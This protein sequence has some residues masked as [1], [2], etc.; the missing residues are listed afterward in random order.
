MASSSATPNNHSGSFSTRAARTTH[1]EPEPVVS[2]S[3]ENPQ[4]PVQDFNFNSDHHRTPHLLLAAPVALDRFQSQFAS[5]FTRAVNVDRGASADVTTDCT[6]RNQSPLRAYLSPGYS[7]VHS[8]SMASDGM[9]EHSQDSNRA[10]LMT[11]TRDIEGNTP[12]CTA[13]P[14]PS[15]RA[16]DSSEAL[17]PGFDSSTSETTTTSWLSHPSST[18]QPGQINYHSTGDQSINSMATMPPQQSQGVPLHYHLS[19]FPEHP[20]P[21][22]LFG[23]TTNFAESPV[24]NEAPSFDNHSFDGP[25]ARFRESHA[26]MYT[27]NSGTDGHLVTGTVVATALGQPHD[28]DRKPMQCKSC[29]FII[30]D[31]AEEKMHDLQCERIPC[32]FQFAGCRSRC[33]G[34]NEWKRHIRTQHLLEEAFV[35]PSCESKVFNR[36]DLFKQHYIRMHCTKEEAEAL[37]KRQCSTVFQKKLEELQLQAVRADQ[38]AHPRADHCFMMGCQTTFAEEDSW[39]KCLEHVAKHQE[40]VMRGKEEI[41]DFQFTEEQLRYFQ[42]V[43]ALARKPDGEWVLGRQSDGERARTNK[44]KNPKPQTDARPGRSAVSKSQRYRQR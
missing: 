32:L 9:Y 13:T 19:N 2:S 30:A 29:K 16:G 6:T 26:N 21:N 27:I 1:Q 43:G 37:R 40:A 38:P 20:T 4:Q 5:G 23:N 25:A 44:K 28:P 34:K 12:N 35:C 17:L 7:S 11:P 15:R 36:K 3:Y 14:A 39:G 41:R 18:Q 10:W 22:L 24:P 33:K 8:P 31:A 42:D